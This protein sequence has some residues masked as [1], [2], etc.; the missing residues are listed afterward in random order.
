MPIPFG[1]P[2]TSGKG[3]HIAAIGERLI[4]GV[5]VLNTLDHI[6]GVVRDLLE[7]VFV[8]RARS[9]E[10]QIHRSHIFHRADN[11]PDVDGILRLIQDHRHGGH[12]RFGHPTE[13]ED[14]RRPDVDEQERS[15]G[16]P[17]TGEDSRLSERELKPEGPRG[18]MP[19]PAEIT[20][21]GR[22]WRI[23]GTSRQDELTTTPGSFRGALIHDE[24]KGQ[25]AR[26]IDRQVGPVPDETHGPTVS[27]RPC[28]GGRRGER[29]LAGDKAG[30]PHRVVNRHTQRG[31]RERPAKGS[32]V[33]LDT[34]RVGIGVFVVQK[35]PL[36]IGSNERVPVHIHVDDNLVR[37]RRDLHHRRGGA[38][39]AP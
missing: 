25:Q 38:R 15:S 28:T 11:G 12:Y 37:R 2:A 19:V 16:R 27:V 30:H 5:E 1:S 8:I 35:I 29:P 9:N 14:C 22:E 24:V 36:R 21:A 20:E 3:N 26:V 33:P 7:P 4:D 34:I 23:D 6:P 13:F 18:V 39:L 10:A 17:P 32:P 31:L